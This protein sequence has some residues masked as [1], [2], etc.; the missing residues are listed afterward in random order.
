MEG[1]ALSAQRIPTYSR[2]STPE[3]LLF[4]PSGSSVVLTRLSGSRFRLFLRK[5]GSAGHRTR[6]LWV[7]SQVLWSIDHRGGRRSTHTR[8]NNEITARNNYRRLNRRITDKYR[9]ILSCKPVKSSIYCIVGI[10]SHTAFVMSG[11]R[12]GA[13]RHPPILRIVIG[14]LT[15]CCCS[16]DRYHG[17]R[18]ST[19]LDC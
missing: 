19:S 6:D 4:L 11:E 8:R 14:V 2:F 3:P 5:S 18:A 15:Y 17:Y 10:P 1:V 9:R 13:D 7:C 12:T 16:D